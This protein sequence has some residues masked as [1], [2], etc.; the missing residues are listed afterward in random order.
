M[1]LAEATDR[2]IARHG[3]DG[4]KAVGHQR[5]LRTHAGGGA[6]GF[7]AGVASSNDNNVERF[8]SGDHGKAFIAGRRISEAVSL[9][10]DVSRET[11][12]S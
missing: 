7:A 12:G 5:G 4:R 6:G 9:S 10:P 1:T 8:R 3:P 2:G 11:S